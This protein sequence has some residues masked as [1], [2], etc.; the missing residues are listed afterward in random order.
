MTNMEALATE[1]QVGRGGPLFTERS[2]GTPAHFSG[3]DS[4]A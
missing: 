1:L 2:I 4:I 3:P